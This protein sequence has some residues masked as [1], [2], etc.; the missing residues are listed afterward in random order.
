MDWKD[1]NLYS[2]LLNLTCSNIDSF[3]DDP[4]SVFSVLARIL[5]ILLLSPF[6]VN[7]FLFNCY[8]YSLLKIVIKICNYSDEVKRKS[9]EMKVLIAEKIGGLNQPLSRSL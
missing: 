4:F 5:F 7:F 3:L 2:V 9:S 8:F 1:H 6:L